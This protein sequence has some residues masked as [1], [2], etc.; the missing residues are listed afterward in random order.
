MNDEMRKPP[1][2]DAFDF[3]TRVEEGVEGGDAQL[4]SA[5]RV[6]EGGRLSFSNDFVWLLGGVEEFPKDRELVVVDTIRL[7]QKWVDKMP[8]G[9]IAVEPGKKWPNVDVM[10]EDCPKSEWGKHFNGQAQ[11]RGSER[12]SPTSSISPRCRDTPGR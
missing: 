9:H 10:N 11:V 1:P 5:P 4:A 3:D 8:A 6:I 2:L 7:V 12:A